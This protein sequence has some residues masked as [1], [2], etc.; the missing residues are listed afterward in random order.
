MTGRYWFVSKD[1]VWLYIIVASLVFLHHLALAGH[2]TQNGCAEEGSVTEHYTTPF[3]LLVLFRGQHCNLGEDYLGQHDLHRGY[4]NNA[5]VALTLAK[6]T[7][8]GKANNCTGSGPARI[9]PDGKP[10][11]VHMAFPLQWADLY[12]DMEHGTCDLSHISRGGPTPL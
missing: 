4:F 7:P 10:I 11:H 1:G 9:S 8:G 6:E 2:I 12:M 3:S 5:K